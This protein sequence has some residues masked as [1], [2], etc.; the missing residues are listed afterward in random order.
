MTGVEE[1][2]GHAGCDD[3]PAVVG[4]PHHLGQDVR[5]VLF[6]VEGLD[7]LEVG[8]APGDQAIDVPRV[9]LLDQAASSSIGA[10]RSRVAGV[11]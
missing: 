1:R 4:Q 7:R 6:A 8:L 5:D 3:L 10:A 11:A 9:R 2:H